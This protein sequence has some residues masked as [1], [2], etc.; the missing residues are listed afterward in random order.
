VIA[1]VAMQMQRTRR[2]SLDGVNTGAEVLRSSSLRI[3]SPLGDVAEKPAE[4]RWEAVA[5]AAR[6]QVRLLEVDRTK[7]WSAETAV[8]RIDLPSKVQSLIVPTKT[9]LCEVSAIDNAGHKI[10]ESE[11]VRFRLS[12][13]TYTH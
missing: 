12:Q 6:Y 13:N 11:P 3:L 10:A 7:L 5:N 2:P 4:I 1:G 9:V 8:T